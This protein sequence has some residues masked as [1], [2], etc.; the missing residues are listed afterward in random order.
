MKCLIPPNGF[1]VTQQHFQCG[2]VSLSL[3]LF[4]LTL[5][6]MIENLIEI[7]KIILTKQHSV[8]VCGKIITITLMIIK[9]E[10][11]VSCEVFAHFPSIPSNLVEDSVGNLLEQQADCHLNYLNQCIN[12]FN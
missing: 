4:A 2:Q 12:E 5:I 6:R 1:F 10:V 7:H 8:S 11:L 3:V 9:E